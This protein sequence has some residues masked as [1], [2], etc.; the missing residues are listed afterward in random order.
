[1][2]ATHGAAL[3]LKQEMQHTKSGECIYKSTV[4]ALSSKHICRHSS[5]KTETLAQPPT[6]RQSKSHMLMRQ[7]GLTLLL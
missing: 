1:M 5:A 7:A 4:N 6:G 2:L 3:S